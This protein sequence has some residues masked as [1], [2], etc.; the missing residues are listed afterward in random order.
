MLESFSYLKPLVFAFVTEVTLPDP[1]STVNGSF[2]VLFFLFYLGFSLFNSSIF[3]TT[4]CFLVHLHLVNFSLSHLAWVLLALFGGRHWLSRE[5][6][7][8]LGFL[9]FIC[10]PE[11]D[12]SDDHKGSESNEFREDRL[13]DERIGFEE[14]VTK[15]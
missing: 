10:F 8:F 6:C 15:S 5:L 11:L 12:V 9:D 7:L 1:V 2:F 14:L 4:S 13:H 3:S